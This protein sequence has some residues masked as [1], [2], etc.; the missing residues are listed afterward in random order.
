M[1]ELRHIIGKMFGHTSFIYENQIM[2][3]ATGELISKLGKKEAV[4]SQKELV[5]NNVLDYFVQFII[6]ALITF[7]I[8]KQAWVRIFR[9]VQNE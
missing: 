9:F 8:V 1:K 7:F 2:T 3:I 6:G 4:S 5:S